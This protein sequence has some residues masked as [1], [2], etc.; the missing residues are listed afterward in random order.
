MLLIYVKRVSKQREKE[1]TI[2]GSLV[3]RVETMSVA[4]AGLAD[5]PLSRDFSTIHSVL[6]LLLRFDL[7]PLAAGVWCPPAS[8][9][10][11]WR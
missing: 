2:G 3:V 1:K 7:L 4:E 5:L 11:E 9:R 8:G 6:H 10:G